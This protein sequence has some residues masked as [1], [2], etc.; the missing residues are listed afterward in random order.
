MASALDYKRIVDEQFAELERIHK[1]QSQPDKDGAKTAIVRDYE[2]GCFLIVRFGWRD[3]SRI[4]AVS[5]F[6]R[7]CLSR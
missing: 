6:I 3:K 4:R 2:R 5:I 7:C 1:Q